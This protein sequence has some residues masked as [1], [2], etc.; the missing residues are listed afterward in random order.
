MQDALET[1]KRYSGEKELTKEIVE[2]FSG[3]VN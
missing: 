2:A 1:L 3:S